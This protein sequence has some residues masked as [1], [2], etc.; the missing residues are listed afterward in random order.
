M[1]IA[2]CKLKHIARLFAAVV[3][4]SAAIRAQTAEPRRFDVV[5]IK[6]VHEIRQSARVGSQPNGDFTMTGMTIDSIILAAAFPATDVRPPVEGLPDWA[7]RDQYDIIAKAPAGSTRA[8]AQEMLHYL[9]IDRFHVQSHVEQREQKAFGLVVARSDGRL[10][11]NLKKSSI[12]CSPRAADAPPPAPEPDPA[13]RCGVSMGPGTMATGGTTMDMFVRNL[14]T[15]PGGMVVNRT[16]LDGSFAL[17]LQFAMPGARPDA[18]PSEFP[19]ITTAL[20]EQLGLKLVPEKVTVPVL[21]VDHIDR[22]TED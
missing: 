9:L 16:G 10:G 17:S 14:G 4:A 20:Q 18:A 19:E 8:Q 12:D 2:N 5:S 11:P 21:V 13:K 1:Q 22:P 6:P 3:V 7:Y 15:L